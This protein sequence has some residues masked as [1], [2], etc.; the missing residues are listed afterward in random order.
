[1]S[2]SMQEG[3]EPM[4]PRNDQ[5]PEVMALDAAA[6]QHRRAVAV[7]PVNEE[8]LRAV[9]S[10]LGAGTLGA[11]T[12][13]SV[14]RLSARAP[15]FDGLAA[16]Y[17]FNASRWDS[18]ADQVYCAPNQAPAGSWD[19]TVVYVDFTA[20]AVG[21]YQIVVS[22]GGK[23]AVT[24]VRGPWGVTSKSMPAGSESDTVGISWTGSGQ[25]WFTISFS[26]Q[27]MGMVSAVQI[28]E[29]P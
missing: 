17:C 23:N 13:V 26:G 24:H 6:E 5:T 29:M 20:P 22:Y 28:F 8:T 4:S 2:I 12:P 27:W 10:T 18:P 7:A 3:R 25:L 21:T 15:W 9:A 1:M 11:G 16:L 14:V 19:G